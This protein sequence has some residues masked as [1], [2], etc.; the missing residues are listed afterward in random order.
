MRQL[1]ITVSFLV[2]PIR[3]HALF[4]Q[5]KFERLLVHDRAYRYEKGSKTS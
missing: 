3:D 2:S 4:K 5:K 1:S